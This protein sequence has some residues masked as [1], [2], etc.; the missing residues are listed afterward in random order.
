MRLASSVD[1][2]CLMQSSSIYPGLLICLSS[3]Q[4]AKDVGAKC[5][6][7]NLSLYL[8]QQLQ[9]LESSLTHTLDLMH[10][11]SA[12]QY[13]LRLN[14]STYM[15]MYTL[16]KVSFNNMFTFLLSYQ[17]H[18]NL[19]ALSNDILT[20]DPPIN[21]LL[22]TSPHLI[23]TIYVGAYVLVPNPPICPCSQVAHLQHP[24]ARC[25]SCSHLKFQQ[26]SA[27][28]HSDVG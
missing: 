11:S 3:G 26:W 18:D 21:S 5:N 14:A 13:S 20:S 7:Y 19:A 23:N 2:N 17:S 22:H 4:W 15:W 24:V 12:F 6:W 8:T 10:C 16:D 1:L 27:R 9:I 25:S 28:H